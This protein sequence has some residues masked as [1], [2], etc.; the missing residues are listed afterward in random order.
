MKNKGI[1][2]F[3]QVTGPLFEEMVLEIS[4]YFKQSTFLVT[5]KLDRKLKNKN[6]NLKIAPSY[7]RRNIKSKFFSWIRFSIY[8]F[9]FSLFSKRAFFIRLSISFCKSIFLQR[10][11][12]SYFILCCF[13]V[14]GQNHFLF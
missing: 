3:N 11:N 2:I 9:V 8:S 6:I 7:N 10:Y 1:V 12:F 4:K 14:Y 13:H 5:G